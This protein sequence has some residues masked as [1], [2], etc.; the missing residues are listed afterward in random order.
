MAEEHRKT[1]ESWL[2]TLDSLHRSLLEMSGSVVQ[3]SDFPGK[4]Q[5]L[6]RTVEI[7]GLLVELMS[8]LWSLDPDL[9]P[10]GLRP[11]LEI[12]LTE[13]FRVMEGTNAEWRENALESVLSYAP[14]AVVEAAQAVSSYEER[15]TI[16]RQWWDAEPRP[17]VPLDHFDRT[18][19]DARSWRRVLAAR[20]L[21]RL[22][23][24]SLIDPACGDVDP[25]AV[26]RWREARARKGDA[27]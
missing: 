10:T 27:S 19:D 25:E 23:E 20:A 4:Q 15:R 18:L 8:D 6:A 26:K 16:L 5:C 9:V 22:G 17:F 12:D 3:W 21:L 24:P 11:N 13:Y 7:G 2:Q 14:Q 1:L